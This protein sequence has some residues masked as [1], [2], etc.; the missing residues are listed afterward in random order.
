[1]NYLS[2]NNL[3]DNL[4]ERSEYNKKETLCAHQKN[5]HKKSRLTT[6]SFSGNRL[7]LEERTD[8]SRNMRVNACNY[9]LFV[10]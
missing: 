10:Y 8:D 5:A 3:K 7:L 6:V 9:S 4:Y 1:M 2:K